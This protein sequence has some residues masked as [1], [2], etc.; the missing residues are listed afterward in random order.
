MV[1][2]SDPFEEYTYV[3][4]GTKGPRGEFFKL[5]FEP[6]EKIEPRQRWHLAQFVP[7]EKF[8]PRRSL[9]N[10]PLVLTRGQCYNHYCRQL[11]PIF[12]EKNGV[13]LDMIAFVI[14]YSILCQNRKICDVNISKIITLSFTCP[15]NIG[16]R[17]N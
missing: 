4:W 10:S 17:V 6:A 1:V 11:S 12:G 15:R 8:A 14:K 9:K 2:V 7:T 16:P 3:G 5:I 13:F